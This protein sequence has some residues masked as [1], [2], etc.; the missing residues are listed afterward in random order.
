[1]AFRVVIDACVL[2]PFALRDALLY[3][4]Y[5]DLF[6][7]KWSEQILGEMRRNLVANDT[8]AEADAANLVEALDSTF[9]EAMVD[10][11]A[12]DALVVAMRNDVADRHVA[13]AAVAAGA[14]QITTINLKHFQASDL[15]PFG[16][17]AVHPDKFLMS[18]WNGWPDD[19]VLAIR[20]HADDRF[21]GDQQLLAEHLGSVAPNYAAVVRSITSGS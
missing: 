6:A 15:A 2:Y 13:A 20:D 19:T 21:G 14:E 5:R 7:P 8:M 10:S 3:A 17:E 12:I 4:A 18:L 11:E 16:V 9:P 1:V